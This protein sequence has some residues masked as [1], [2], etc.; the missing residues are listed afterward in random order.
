MKLRNERRDRERKREKE[1]EEMKGKRERERGCDVGG[2]ER[3]G[4]ESDLSWN[5][6]RWPAFINVNREGEQTFF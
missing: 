5:L 2:E 6:H 3:R 4:E 1:R